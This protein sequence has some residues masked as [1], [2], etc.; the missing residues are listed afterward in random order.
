MITFK[1]S[2]AAAGKLKHPIVTLGVFDG[3][4]RGHQHLLK[5]CLRRAR[6][7]K[8]PAVVYTFDPHPVRILSPE[9]CPPLLMTN[10]QKLE[11]LEALGFYATVIERFN[12][13]FSH[14]SADTF[15]QKI[16]LER[17][18]AREIY[19]GYDFTFGAGRKGSTALLE[20]LGDKHDMRV[21]VVDAFFAGEYLI[22][23]TAIR[24]QLQAGKI[25]LA[26]R[27]LGRPYRISGTVI[28]GDGMGHQLGFPTANIKSENELLP[29]MGVY[30][31]VCIIGN[32]RYPSVTNIG[33]RPT[34]HGTE[35]RTETHLL[36]FKRNILGKKI[37]L[38]FRQRL[39]PE[40]HF[41]GPEELVQQIHK[42]V[43]SAEKFFKNKRI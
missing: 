24:Q 31:T 40:I 38:D 3:M 32:R 13:R 29:A 20:K 19:V 10:K 25:E 34:F 26:A 17:L 9:G 11:Q 35:M 5:A 21:H 41:A 36:H 8:R 22:S 16:L 18:Q 39:R 33:H 4:H 14:Q 15:F 30:A 2:K 43:A 42:D 1:G 12:K 6:S 7:L 28:K 27:L 23:S 37:S